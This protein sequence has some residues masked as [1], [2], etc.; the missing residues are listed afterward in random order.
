MI[1]SIIGNLLHW[2]SSN[3]KR[4]ESAGV[5][6]CWIEVILEWWNDEVEEM[7]F[8]KEGVY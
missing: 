4:L 3:S 6:E 2:G 7:E 1:D 8:G 5:M